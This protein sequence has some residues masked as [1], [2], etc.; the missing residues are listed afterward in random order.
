MSL[1]HYCALSQSDGGKLGFIDGT[2][3]VKKPITPEKYTEVKKTIAAN[4]EFYS[5]E[6]LILLSLSQID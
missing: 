1:Y 2:I 5:G 3:E 4:M 6:G